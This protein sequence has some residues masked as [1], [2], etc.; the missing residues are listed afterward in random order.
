MS[1]IKEELDEKKKEQSKYDG[2]NMQG[3]MRA[4][5]TGACLR[6][7]NPL[8]RRQKVALLVINQVRSKVGLF[9]GE[10]QAAGGRSLDYYLGVNL[11]CIARKADRIEKN[12]DI[13]GIKG[14]IE[15]IKNK[16]TA[17]F[18][19]C[20]FT[21]IFDEGLD[22]FSGMLNELSK[23]GKITEKAGWYTLNDTGKKFRESKFTEM[24]LDESVQEFSEL[25]K[26]LG[27][28]NAE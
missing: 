1:P 10:T 8:L 21:L 27:V 9:A 14:Y 19:K 26:E 5:V 22:P 24:V 7:I 17:P 18:K 11:K 23:G 12:G 6:K 15:N 25:R 13:V 20:S 3:A 4:K 16:V 2:H 28:N